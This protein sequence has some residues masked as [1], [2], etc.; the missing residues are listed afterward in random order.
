M[1]TLIFVMMA[2]THANNFVPSLV[3][4][5]RDQCEA[6]AQVIYKQSKQRLGYTAS[7]WCVE[8]PRDGMVLPK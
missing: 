6:A 1:N 3:F 4:T 8:L 7:P 5:S 2:Y